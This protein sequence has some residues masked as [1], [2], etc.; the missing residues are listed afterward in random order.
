MP[1]RRRSEALQGVAAVAARLARRNTQVDQ[2]VA[3]EQRQVAGGDSQFV[4]AEI[5][6]GHQHLTLGVAL[7]RAAARMASPASI[8]SSGSSPCRM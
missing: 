6:A 8:T 5:R 2:L 7:A 3:A 4:P 1:G